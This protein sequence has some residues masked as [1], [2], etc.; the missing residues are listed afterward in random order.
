[1]IHREI[2]LKRL[3][4]I[5][6]AATLVHIYLQED[7]HKRASG[8]YAREDLECLSDCPVRRSPTPVGQCVHE[9]DAPANTVPSLNR[10]QEIGALEPDLGKTHTGGRRGRVQ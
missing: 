10:R 3:H 4:Y 9:A 8:Q 6:L 1:M 7:L 2:Q 5:L